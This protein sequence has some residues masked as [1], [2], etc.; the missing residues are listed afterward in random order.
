YAIGILSAYMHGH[1]IR[2]LR[3]DFEIP[4]NCPETG[5]GKLC[6]SFYLNRTGI[7]GSHAPMPNVD[8]VCTPTGNHS[9]AKLLA[10]K[11]SRTIINI[12]LRVNS[13]QSVIN[14]GA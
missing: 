10:T 4:M 3:S 13:I 5:S 8:M 11:P 2:I 14:L 12:S 7:F 9:S 1:T 6:V